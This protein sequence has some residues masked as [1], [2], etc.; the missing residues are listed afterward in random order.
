LDISQNAKKIFFENIPLLHT[1]DGGVSWNTG[2]FKRHHLK[3]LYDLSVSIP[4]CKIIETGSGN[5]TI[6]FLLANPKK[7]VSISPDFKLFSR[8]ENLCKEKGISMKN[9]EYIKSKS[10]WELPSL[11]LKKNEFDIGLIDGCHGW[12]TAFIDLYYIYYMLRPGGYLII[13]D[14]NLH[15]IKE[16]ANFLMAETTKF[17]LVADFEK[18]L[19][20]K[21]L[22]ND[23]EFGEWNEQKYIIYKT[24]E[25]RDRGDAFTLRR[26]AS[27]DS[28]SLRFGRRVLVNTLIFMIRVFTRILSRIRNL[29]VD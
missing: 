4:E 23:L 14:V 1:F 26:L 6:S 28:H 15:S 18:A 27:E 17:A 29:S 9:L 16:I 21:K 2:G 20:F 10:E 8:I 12:P 7:L 5:S 3:Y 11:A 25:S 19:I 24:N 13:D 22:T